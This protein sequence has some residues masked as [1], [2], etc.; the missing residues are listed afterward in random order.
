LVG[1][2]VA[3]LVSGATEAPLYVLAFDQITYPIVSREQTLTGWEAAFKPILAHGRT[4]MGSCVDYLI[5]K[6]IIVEQFVYVTDEGET[7]SPFF[8]VKY[9]EYKKKFNVTPHVVVINVEG[10]D[11]TFSQRLKQAGI[12]YDIYSPK[13]TDYY[14]LPGLIS[15]LSR[16]TKIDLLYE[17]MDTPLPSRKEYT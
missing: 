15:L 3:A 2:S 13:E 9:E 5:R 17:V 10:N 7:D 14:S 4:N 8:P 6:N 12:E 11:H 1:K 16:K